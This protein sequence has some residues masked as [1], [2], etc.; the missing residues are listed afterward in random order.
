M[1]D[2]LAQLKYTPFPGVPNVEEIEQPTGER[3]LAPTK[4]WSASLGGSPE[5]QALTAFYLVLGI[6][7]APSQVIMTIAAVKFADTEKKINFEEWIETRS[8]WSKDDKEGA[9]LVLKTVDV[10]AERIKTGDKSSLFG[11]LPGLEEKVKDLEDDWNL[12]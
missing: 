11:D 5:A 8:G 3:C 10:R 4:E 7:G 2:P 1:K 6:M 12:N 9:I